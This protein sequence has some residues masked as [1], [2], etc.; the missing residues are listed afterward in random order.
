MIRYAT[1]HE[2]ANRIRDLTSLMDAQFVQLV[3]PFETAFVRH[4]DAWTMEG[5]PRTG[6]RYRQYATCP[7]PTP[8]DRLLFILSY[9]K[10][11]ALQVAHATLFGMSQPN[12][13]KWIHVLLPVLHQTL[14]DVGDVPA[15][16]LDELRQ[17]LADLAVPDG[18]DAHPLFITTAPN[19]RSRAP[20]IRMSNPRVRAARKS[21]IPSKMCC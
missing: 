9:L 14:V 7:L 6:R 2:K 13:N 10:V 8:E 5:L 21:V 12:A 11:A 1:E 20:K 16:H 4:M 18:S 17:R 3:G 15:R 19:A